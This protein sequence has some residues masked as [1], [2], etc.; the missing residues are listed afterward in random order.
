M[1]QTRFTLHSDFLIFLNRRKLRG[2]IKREGK[3]KTNTKEMEIKV[4]GTGKK[5][6]DYKYG[7]RHTCI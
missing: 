7:T 6:S 4:T 2:K 5:E 1:Y 3:K